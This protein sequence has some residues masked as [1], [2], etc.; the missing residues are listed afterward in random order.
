METVFG[1][2]IY[3]YSNTFDRQSTDGAI[4]AMIT[5]IVARILMDRWADTFH[6]RLRKAGVEIYLLAKYVDDCN[7][8]TSLIKAG[9]KWHKTKVEG[10]TAW[11]LK[12]SP[13]QERKDKEEGKS[14]Q[15]RTM[16]LLVE[17]GNSIIKGTRPSYRWIS[18]AWRIFGKYPVVE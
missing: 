8:A 2:Y 7:L 16:D 3:Q 9:Y 4:G 18:S 15:K 6:D 13:E 11:S 5:S 14:D 1:N 12:W 17:A 10:E